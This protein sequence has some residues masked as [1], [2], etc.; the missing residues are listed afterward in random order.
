MTLGT[1]APTASTSPRPQG[2]D[3]EEESGKGR[4]EQRENQGGKDPRV[5]ARTGSLGKASAGG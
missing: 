5:P 2:E 3:E 1:A 4:H